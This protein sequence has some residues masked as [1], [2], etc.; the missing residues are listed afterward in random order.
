[1]KQLGK[2]KLNEISFEKLREKEMRQVKGGGNC[3]CVNPIPGDYHPILGGDTCNQYLGN[4]PAQ[5]NFFSAY[6][7]C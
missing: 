3:F 6:Y 1:M 2:L 4:N 5:W 7:G